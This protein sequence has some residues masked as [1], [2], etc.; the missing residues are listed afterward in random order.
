MFALLFGGDADMFDG[1]WLKVS[2]TLLISD[3]VSFISECLDFLL[4]LR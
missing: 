2:R 3:S 1:H 4:K